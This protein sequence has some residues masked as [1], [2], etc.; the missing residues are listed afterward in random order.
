MILSVSLVVLLV[1]VRNSCFEGLQM[2]PSVAMVT[3]ISALQRLLS[4][5][6]LSS[7]WCDN[8]VCAEALALLVQLVQHVRPPGLTLQTSEG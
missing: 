8:T 2:G 5:Q 1:V 7:G 4:K 3:A 6:F